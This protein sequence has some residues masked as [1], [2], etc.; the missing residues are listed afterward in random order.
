MKNTLLLL[1]LLLAN[2]AS[3]QKI[4]EDKKDDFKNIQVQR[5]DWNKIIEKMQGPVIYVRIAKLDTTYYL[6]AKVAYNS[7]EGFSISKGAEF[8]FKLANDTTVVLTAMETAIAMK[9]AVKMGMAAPKLFGTQVQY[10]LT[11]DQRDKLRKAPIVKFRI[12]RTDDYDDQEIKE[13]F[14]QVVQEL[15]YLFPER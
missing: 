12:Y 11:K 2:T 7:R 14:Q 8:L 1:I 10:L 5:T 9:G 3:A 6:E 4:V 13:K 15:L